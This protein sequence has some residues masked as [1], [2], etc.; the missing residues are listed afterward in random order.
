ME[1][2]LAHTVNVDY[3]FSSRQSS[4]TAGTHCELPPPLL[5]CTLFWEHLHVGRCFVCLPF[6][7]CVRQHIECKLALKVSTLQRD[8]MLFFLLNTLSPDAGPHGL[9]GTM[10]KKI[11]QRNTVFYQSVASSNSVTQINVITSSLTDLVFIHPFFIGYSFDLH[12]MRRG[13]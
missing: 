9:F 7:H 1:I 4:Q 12:R 3:V 10:I 6:L 2:V 8:R 5:N 13:P 11:Y